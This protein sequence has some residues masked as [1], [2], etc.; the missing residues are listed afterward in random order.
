MFKINIFNKTF[1]LLV[2][3]KIFWHTIY[4]FI[5]AIF[6]M[7]RT[8]NISH[9]LKITKSYKLTVK[10]LV[11]FKPVLFLLDNLQISTFFTMKL[12]KSYVTL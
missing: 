5:F 2:K 3:I 7:L 9:L 8:R 6:T 1:W 12:I 4:L 11:Y 10:N